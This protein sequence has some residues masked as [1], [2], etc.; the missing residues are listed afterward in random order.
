M[1]CVIA[2]IVAFIAVVISIIMVSYKHTKFEL[3]VMI[4][5]ALFLCLI[6]FCGVMRVDSIDICEKLHTDYKEIILVSDSIDQSE[7]E[8]LRY[9]FFKRVEEYNKLYDLY[10]Q[11]LNSPWFNWLIYGNVDDIEHIEFNWRGVSND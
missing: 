11:D 10:V 2:T 8:Y 1:I 9:I 7:N 6:L 5:T 4:S 3:M